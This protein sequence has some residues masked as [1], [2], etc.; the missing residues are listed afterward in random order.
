[1]R[2]PDAAPLG[3]G[4]NDGESQDEP[5]VAEARAGSRG[6]NGDEHGNNDKSAGIPP[7]A[8]SC[9]LKLFP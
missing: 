2:Q 9:G 7:D 6:N 8:R 3:C 5:G 1:M 4:R